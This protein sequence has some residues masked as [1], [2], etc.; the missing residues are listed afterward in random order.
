MHQVL[1]QF[2]ANLVLCSLVTLSDR[3]DVLLMHDTGFYGD[4]SSAAD[5]W[6]YIQCLLPDDNT[7]AI[8]NY[9]Q[10]YT[11]GDMEVARVETAR[12]SRHWNFIISVSLRA[13]KYDRGVAMQAQFVLV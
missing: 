9:L 4:L 12:L 10:E 6:L 5:V 13:E 11:R 7:K 1:S 2:S 8:L 3:C